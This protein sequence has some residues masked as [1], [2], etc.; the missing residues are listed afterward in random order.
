M[1]TELYDFYFSSLA[2]HQ[3]NISKKSFCFR[4]TVPVFAKTQRI[5]RLL[6]LEQKSESMYSVSGTYFIL[7]H[8]H[9]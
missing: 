1:V 9:I 5:H 6:L 7:S 4:E 2:K 8:K 3:S